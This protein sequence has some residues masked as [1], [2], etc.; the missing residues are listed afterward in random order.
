MKIYLIIV[1]EPFFHPQ[2]IEKLLKKKKRDIVGISIVPN[3]SPNK[4]I[5]KYIKQQL[6]FFG[7]KPFL[8]LGFYT[9]YYKFLDI[10]SNF[11]Q[12]SRFYSVKKAAFNYKIPVYKVKNV[13]DSEHLDY[14]KKV[15]PEIIL[16]AQ[17]QIFKKDIL[18]LPSKYC[19]NRHGS[20]L[21]KYAGLWP[22]FWAMLAGEREVGVTIHTMTEEIDRG[23]IVSQRKIKITP[24]DT[25]YS[26]Y[27]KT[28][29]NSVGATLEAFEKIEN[30][31]DSYIKIDKE[32]VLYFS[33]P[34]K[35]EAD[36]FRRQGLKFI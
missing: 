33:M 1:E 12:L 13:N 16:S 9:I 14:L 8:I 27:K 20:L 30:Q 31:N 21:P 25:L 7:I 28:F 29:D 5:I 18:K 35:K 15:S 23:E 32:K 17:G 6:N 34:G 19:L 26:L 22:I 4:S 10:L 2:Y 3:I 24:D 36:L 11:F